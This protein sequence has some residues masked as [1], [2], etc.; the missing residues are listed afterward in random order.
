MGLRPWKRD[1]LP[2]ERKHDEEA[3]NATQ[4]ELVPA[5]PNRKAFDEIVNA[6]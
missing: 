5:L 4:Y 3:I 2:T 1:W 6:T